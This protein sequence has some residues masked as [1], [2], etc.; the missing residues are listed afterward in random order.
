MILDCYQN[1]S[2]RISLIKSFRLNWK[3]TSRWSRAAHMGCGMATRFIAVIASYHFTVL[4]VVIS[5]PWVLF[6]C[7]TASI[8]GFVDTKIA[9]HLNVSCPVDTE[10]KT[11]KEQYWS[12]EITRSTENSTGIESSLVVNAF[13]VRTSSCKV[14][15]TTAVTTWVILVLHIRDEVKAWPA[16][17]CFTS[18]GICIKYLG[19][20]KCLDQILYRSVNSSRFGE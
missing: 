1:S 8:C 5:Y 16:A 11:F 19:I 17:G 6:K 12:I 18:S 10:R 7:C 20:Y 13:Y 15:H 2:Q 9:P 4:T 14:S 3:L